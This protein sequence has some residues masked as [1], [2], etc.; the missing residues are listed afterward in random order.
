MVCSFFPQL[1]NRHRGLTEG[2][3]SAAPDKL[4]STLACVLPSVW[5]FKTVR[6]VMGVPGQAFTCEWSNL[7]IRSQEEQVQGGW[8]HMLW[9]VSSNPMYSWCSLPGQVELEEWLGLRSLGHWSPMFFNWY[10]KCIRFLYSTENAGLAIIPIYCGCST[11][12]GPCYKLRVDV[13]F[14]ASSDVVK[15][16]HL[17][18][19]LLLPAVTAACA[20]PYICTEHGPQLHLGT[21]RLSVMCESI[22]LCLSFFWME[23]AV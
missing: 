23:G 16:S 1:W 21:F 15:S 6:Y 17:L 8:K 13:W 11:C 14:S 22:Y 5:A 9:I 7:V 19:L 3:P 12:H 20:G 2:L 4:K 18:L 10:T